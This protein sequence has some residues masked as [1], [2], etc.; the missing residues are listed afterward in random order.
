MK[1]YMTVAKSGEARNRTEQS[2]PTTFKNLMLDKM[3]Y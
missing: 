3:M 1:E 2:S